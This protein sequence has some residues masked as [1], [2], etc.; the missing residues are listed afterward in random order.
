MIARECG[1]SSFL[2]RNWGKRIIA[3]CDREGS[4]FLCWDPKRKT[5]IACSGIFSNRKPVEEASDCMARTCEWFF[6]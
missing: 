3:R 6:F 1:T 2:I 5:M 4:F